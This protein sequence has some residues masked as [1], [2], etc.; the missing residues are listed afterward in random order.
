MKAYFASE[1]STHEYK[2]RVNGFYSKLDANQYSSVLYYSDSGHK[3]VNYASS[4]V[5]QAL[6][7]DISSALKSIEPAFKTLYRASE[8]FLDES[9]EVGATLQFP[10]FVSTS[11]NPQVT[12]KFLSK[13]DPTIYVIKTTQGAEISMV[14]DEMEVL[15]PKDLTFVVTKTEKCDFYAAYPETDYHIS[16]ENVTVIYLEEI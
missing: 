6:A 5:G 15:L 8:D 7:E 3:R 16:R 10:A 4:P 1:I 2:E 13:K 12:F 14:H 9:L 11:Y